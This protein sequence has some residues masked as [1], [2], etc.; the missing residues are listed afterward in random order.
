V[1]N[2]INARKLKIEELNVFEGFFNNPIFIIVMAITI[3]IQTVLIQYGG[4]A[5]RLSPLTFNEHLTCI[6]IGML[7][8]VMGYITKIIPEAFYQNFE[9][10]TKQREFDKDEEER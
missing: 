1:F 7:S 10:F 6:M 9:L 5:V 4:F 2:E 3:A 8:L